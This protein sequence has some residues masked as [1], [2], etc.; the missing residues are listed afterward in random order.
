MR[1]SIHEEPSIIDI[2]SVTNPTDLQSLGPFTE[3]KLALN[4]LLG[5]SVGARSWRSLYAMIRR[6]QAVTRREGRVGPAGHGALSEVG[7]RRLSLALQRGSA[8]KKARPVDTA[9]LSKA[10]AAIGQAAADPTIRYRMKRS[11]NFIQSSRLE[12]IDVQMPAGSTSLDEI[13]RKHRRE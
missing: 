2:L 10:I 1:R 7:R 8:G 9:A 4:A 5:L 6:I 13:L 11:R 12:G 3:L